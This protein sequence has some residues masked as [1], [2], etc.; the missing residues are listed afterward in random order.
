MSNLESAGE[1]VPGT[2]ADDEEVLPRVREGLPAG[3]RMRADAH[4]VDLLTSRPSGG[5]DRMLAPE[6][7]ESPAITD[8]AMIRPLVESIARHGVLQPLL[9]QHRHGKYRLIAGHQRLS[10]AVAAGVREVPCRLYDVSDEEATRL[11]D[12]E[13][14]GRGESGLQTSA[15]G[16]APNVDLHA[17]ADLDKALASLSA[18]TDFVSG[19]DSELSRS[20]AS[21]LLRAEV[22]RAACLL[23]AT[24][25]LRQEFSVARAALSVRRLLD[26]VVNGFSPER[27][28]RMVEFDVKSAL[29][30]DGL[31]VSDERLLGIALSS[32]VRSLLSIFGDGTGAIKL[33]AASEST[34]DHVVFT[35]SQ[36]STAVPDAW[37]ARA[38]DAAWLD[39]PGGQAA[40]VSM[41][42][43][44]QVAQLLDGEAKVVPAG[45]GASIVLTIPG[46]L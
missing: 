14:L 5:R 32:A 15:V 2:R 39:R 27:R 1:E 30:S 16:T 21:T 42:A 43:I 24:R 29:P 37:L 9:V 10:A 6:D 19:A 3:Y 33:S 41:L 18:C 44:R 28:L 35:V 4:Y 17:G 38:F 13:R 45:R 23:K 26:Q 31:M 7:I 11:A 25:V 12:A 22:W 36:S 40:M 20:V 34:G 8:A 46:G